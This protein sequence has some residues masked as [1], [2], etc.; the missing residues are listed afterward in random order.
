[1]AEITPTE[2]AF[3]LI[4]RYCQETDVSIEIANTNDYFQLKQIAE[5]ELLPSRLPDPNIYNTQDTKDSQRLL[6]TPTG[7]REEPSGKEFPEDTTL[8]KFVELGYHPPLILANLRLLIVS[9]ELDYVF[10][11][12][13]LQDTSNTGTKGTI[14]I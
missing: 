1:M 4:R 2:L 13:G 7:F 8:L 6:M 14:Q 12:N 9:I 10:R 11:M 3:N 5:S